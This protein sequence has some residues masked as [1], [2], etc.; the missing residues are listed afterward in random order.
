MQ[1]SGSN[2]RIVM[3]RQSEGVNNE[4]YNRGVVMQSL[5]E[6]R[7]GVSAIGANRVE[8][9]LDY[10]GIHS[11]GP[12]FVNESVVFGGDRELSSNDD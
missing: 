11:G 8:K 10:D 2:I 6:R 3:V 9:S 4:G 1:S 5:F 7:P 12:V